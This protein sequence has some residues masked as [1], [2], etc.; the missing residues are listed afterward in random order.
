MM[1]KA[2]HVAFAQLDEEAHQMT[3]ALERVRSSRTEQIERG[4]EAEY[5][6]LRELKTNPA[7]V[8][9]WRIKAVL[10]EA[11][12]EMSEATAGRLLKEFDSRADERGG[13]QG[14]YSH[15]RGRAPRR[16]PGDPPA[17]LDLSR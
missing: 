11:G 7:P 16:Q 4:E 5:I 13:R 2:S 12:I 1:S 17:S 14:A 10:H 9:C 8:G 15:R 6:A 3:Q